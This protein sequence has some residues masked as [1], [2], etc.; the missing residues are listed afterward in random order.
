MRSL[1]VSAPLV[2]LVVI[3]AWTMRTSPEPILLVAEPIVVTRPFVDTTV[4]LQRNETL[5]DALGRVGMTAADVFEML[6]VDDRLNPRRLRPGTA[7]HVRMPLNERPIR[8][9]VRLNDDE[10]LWWSRRGG[11]WVVDVEQIEWRTER[12]RVTG[13]LRG[14][15]WLDLQDAIPAHVLP[16]QQRDNFRQ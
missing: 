1:L 12:F 10:R 7:F 5:T 6:D 11:Q 2:G 9:M 8:V 4:R 15:L 13:R 3:V 14:I 16:G